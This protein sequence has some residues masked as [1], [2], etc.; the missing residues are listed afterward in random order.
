MFVAAAADMLADSVHLAAAVRP[1]ANTTTLSQLC[2][3]GF[4][5]STRF[6]PFATQTNNVL[7]A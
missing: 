3:T 5:I 6:M 7:A 2:R 4:A 1:S